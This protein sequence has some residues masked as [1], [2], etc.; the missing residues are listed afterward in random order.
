MWPPASHKGASV[1]P[2]LGRGSAGSWDWSACWGVAGVGMLCRQ[3]GSEGQQCPQHKQHVTP[4]TAAMGCAVPQHQGWASRCRDGD[5]S[6]WQLSNLAM[7]R[8]QVR[9]KVSWESQTAIQKKQGMG[10]DTPVASLGQGLMAPGWAELGSWTPSRGG[11]GL[12][13]DGQWDF[14]VSSRSWQKA[15]FRTSAEYR[16][17]EWMQIFKN[18]KEKSGKWK[19]VA[20]TKHKQTDISHMYTCV[21]TEKWLPRSTPRL[22]SAHLRSRGRFA[23]ALGNL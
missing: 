2:W 22:C 5:T 13:V 4:V 17:Q 10:Q 9:S 8:W 19:R 14:L 20:E 23:Q 12:G 3:R 16:L 11:G 15:G 21:R 1:L 18:M 7:A 6:C